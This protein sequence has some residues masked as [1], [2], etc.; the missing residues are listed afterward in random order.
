M[1]E[2][3]DGFCYIVK[4]KLSVIYRL[5][6]CACTG[7]LQS[8]LEP[9]DLSADNNINF[10]DFDPQS[11]ELENGGLH[12]TVTPPIDFSTVAGDFNGSA[13]ADSFNYPSNSTGNMNLPTTPHP[14]GAA[15]AG[16]FEAAEAM[17]ARALTNLEALLAPAGAAGS[18]HHAYSGP[19][20]H[21]HHHHNININIQASS[22]PNV[23][24]PASYMLGDANSFSP[25]LFTGPNFG[26][27]APNHHHHN[28]NN[29]NNHHH[30]SY[31][32]PPR[33]TNGPFL[34]PNSIENSQISSMLR[35]S[36]VSCNM[37]S[38]GHHLNSQ[39]SSVEQ[40]Q[41]QQ[42]DHHHHH[43]N[44]RSHALNHSSAQ[45]VVPRIGGD[46]LIMQQT[47]A[48]N[49][50]VNAVAATPEKNRDGR[51]LSYVA[52]EQKSPSS[53]VAAFH[54]F[55]A[56]TPPPRAPNSAIQTEG[57]G[58][59]HAHVYNM[60][61]MLTHEQVEAATTTTTQMPAAI[62]D[63]VAD[64][65]VQEDPSLQEMFTQT[66]DPPMMTTA[67]MDSAQ[68]EG[69]QFDLNEVPVGATESTPNKRKKYHPRVAKDKR[70][71]K[72]RKKLDNAAAAAPVTPH[73]ISEC[74]HNPIHETL[75]T[76]KLV[77]A[78][79]G[80]YLALTAMIFVLLFC[81]RILIN[82]LL[83]SSQL[84][85]CTVSFTTLINY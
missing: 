74:T 27:A 11:L 29:N 46:S 59:L 3:M 61:G 75:S 77:L 79:A 58:T 80:L 41:Q 48:Y 9:Q 56:T 81:R 18:H 63:S 38:W 65:T 68:K 78:A 23:N 26:S 66:Y 28:N 55:E 72:P 32:D 54:A 5:M 1:G 57:L 52:P 10:G 19:E 34:T 51:R 21:Q 36:S 85:S 8:T 62:L 12:S 13:M 37:S 31:L 33:F 30:H 17:T 60:S 71:Y 50:H 49:T 67:E 15:S 16:P 43:H 20:G 39:A 83:L 70:T 44:A 25:S 53:Q 73:G 24:M 82:D 2:W 22:S 14:G 42:G 69:Y 4:L 76:A 40:Q 7:S 45:P 47:H 6:Y 84:K 35:P 64:S